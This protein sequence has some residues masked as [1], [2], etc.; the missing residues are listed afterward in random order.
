L[1]L[2][3]GVYFYAGD[4]FI[5]EEKVTPVIE[6]RANAQ[7]IASSSKNEAKT[8]PRT[9]LTPPDKP[10]SGKF[11]FYS[12]EAIK[13]AKDLEKLLFL[14]NPQAKNLISYID[15]S[16][17]DGHLLVNVKGAMLTVS[18]P[19]QE[20]VYNSITDI[21]NDTKYVREKNYGNWIEVKYWNDE[22]LIETILFNNQDS[23][24]YND[25]LKRK[26]PK[27]EP[28][29]SPASLAEI[30]DLGLEAHPGK[31]TS[32][33]GKFHPNG[34]ESVQAGSQVEELL[35]L[36]APQAER[37]IDNFDTDMSDGHLIVWITK[38]MHSASKPK[39]RAAYDEIYNIWE[40]T[41]Y[42]REK[43]YGRWVEVKYWDTYQSEGFTVIEIRQKG[44]YYANK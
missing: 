14:A 27:T 23:D 17:K 41:K 10:T 3:A 35:F 42:V 13:A 1:V 7:P 29:T 34:M 39:Q 30:E 38:A 18:K 4:Y 40:K 37:F 15:V 11:G 9:G 36:L 19:Q 21:W 26:A 25:L 8:K 2:I 5:K 24:S 6:K 44:A 20:A 43:H 12:M 32:E 33:K 22:K 28:K 31:P 16:P